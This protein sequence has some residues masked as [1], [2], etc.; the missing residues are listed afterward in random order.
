MI[1]DTANGILTAGSWA[2]VAALLVNTRLLTRTF[3]VYSTLWATIGSLTNKVRQAGTGRYSVNIAALGVGT[4]GCWYTG[5]PQ[6]FVLGLNNRRCGTVWFTIFNPR[7][8]RIRLTWNGEATSEGIACVAAN[9]AA[10]G[11]VVANPAYGIVSASIR[12]ARI[13]ALL[14]N[15]R[16]IHRTLRGDGT[17][18]T[19]G[20][21]SSH[22]QGQ[23]G[24]YRLLIGYA[25]L[26]VGTTRSGLT[27]INI[28][29]LW[30]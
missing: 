12:C 15:T 18:W 20:R 27:G 23:A 14:I 9:A 6:R 13:H 22:K 19:A 28:L 5:I 1:D 10:N 29:V 4:T 21:W 26:R 25:T 7:V 24:A 11:A 2:G 30:C 8:T 16:P 3:R 17:F